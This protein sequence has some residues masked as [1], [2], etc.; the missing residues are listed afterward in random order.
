MIVE[1][2]KKKFNSSLGKDVFWTFI[3]QIVVMLCL[4]VVT[5][6]LSNV[7]SID[8]FARYNI[9]KRS[10][11]VITFV[12]LGG[13]GIALPRYL[14]MART[15]RNPT[16]VRITL[17]SSLIYIGIVSF[18]SFIVYIILKNLIC[19]TVTDTDSW[20]DYIVIFGYSLA[21]SLASFYYAYLRGLG[22]FK[23]FNITQ[24]VFHVILLIPLI[25]IFENAIK[26]FAWWTFIYFALLLIYSIVDKKK[27]DWIPKQKLPFSSIISKIKELTRYSGPRM[28]GDFFLFAFSAFPILYISR[29]NS[30]EDVSFF[31]VGVTLFT[32]A[33]PIF[34]FL[35]VI[36][37]PL[38][39]SL[40]TDNKVDE[41]NKLI[42]NLQIIYILIAF[43][44]TGIMF[45]GMK[46][47]ILLFFSEEYLPALFIS[48]I[49][50]FA[51]LPSSLYYLYRNPIDAVTVTPYNLYLLIL[52]FILLV[53]GFMLTSSLIQYAYVYLSVCVIQG[54]GSWIIWKII[55]NSLNQIHNEI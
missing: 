23:D 11:S 22:R 2:I 45:F 20:Y 28:V 29:V 15:K 9:L 8:G 49:L 25:F 24:I 14:A 30:L 35:G 36:L 32:L 37:L 38:V 43:A 50:T 16:K 44:V 55:N 39:S 10:S 47:M 27:Y 19:L 53:A 3:G 21:C 4:L 31:S 26:I 52:C 12:L 1:L 13:M 7:L 46:W 6:V 5:K 48:R 34:S 51:I 42:S 54:L 41:A 33:T 18:I 17:Y 40:V